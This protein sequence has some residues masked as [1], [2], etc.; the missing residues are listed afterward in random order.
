LRVRGANRSEFY[1]GLAYAGDFIHWVLLASSSSI[2]ALTYGMLVRRCWMPDLPLRALGSAALG[3]MSATSAVLATGLYS[4][5]RGLAW[6]AVLW[7]LAFSCVLWYHDG[8]RTL[9]EPRRGGFPPE[10][11]VR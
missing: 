8:R 9:P 5:A 1:P 10:N 2:G 7:W 11:P 3:C 6:F 4:Q